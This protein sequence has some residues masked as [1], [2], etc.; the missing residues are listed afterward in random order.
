MAKRKRLTDD[1]I[2]SFLYNLDDGSIS[3]E[4]S[5]TEI[6]ENIYN[7]ISDEQN[8][9]V[10]PVASS[11]EATN[12]PPLRANRTNRSGIYNDIESVL[13]ENNFDLIHEPKGEQFKVITKKKTSKTQEESVIWSTIPPVLKGKIGAE[14]KITQKAE[15]KAAASHAMTEL[16]CY[17]VFISDSLVNKIVNYTNERI[18]LK[19]DFLRENE[20]SMKNRGYIAVTDAHEIRALFG[21]FFYRGLLGLG[22]HDYQLLFNDVYGPPIFSSTMSSKR[23]CFLHA[24]LAFDDLETRRERWEFDRFAAIREVYEIFN[25]NCGKAVNPHDYIALDE[26]LYPTRNKISFKQFNPNKPAKYGLLFKSINS[27]RYPYTYASVVYAGQPA[28][29]P[30]PFYVKGVTA[31]V[32]ALVNNLAKFSDL[33]GLNISM[34]R[35]YTS[36][37]LFQWLLD[38]KITAIGTIMSNRK[39]LPSEMTSLTERTNLS[40]KVAFETSQKKCSLHSYAVN[41]RSKGKKNVLLLSSMPTI[42]GVTKDDKKKPAIIKLYDFTKGGTDIVDQ[43]MSYYSVNTKS[44]RW[45]LNALS[46]MQDTARVNAQTLWSLNN[47]KEPTKT[48]S[49]LFGTTLAMN[50]VKPHIARRSIVHLKEPIKCKIR[51]LTQSNEDSQQPSTSSNEP[52]RNTPPPD[53]KPRKTPEKGKCKQCTADIYK[54]SEENTVKRK[55]IQSQ[56]W[57]MNSCQW[58][59][60]IVCVNHSIQLCSACYEKRK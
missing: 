38:K 8:E 11:S 54:S 4:Q 60:S 23:F 51:Q 13:T 27:S 16:D 45:T 42:L 43:R 39:G 48:N 50:L 29:T 57:L 5:D 58:C 31:T 21:L 9:P 10:E 22:H 12:V 7:I 24:N 35:L 15:V 19:L 1:E 55:K 34:D 37:E 44:S 41:T 18:Q 28:K 17:G 56:S 2:Q 33:T 30:A 36:L 52:A 53:I 26:T 25:E 6:E 47:G 32:Q 14:N 3:D 40:Y 59:S 46:Y 20:I 49:F